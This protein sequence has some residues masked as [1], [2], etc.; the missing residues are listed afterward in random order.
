[1]RV[2]VS[3]TDHTEPPKRSALQN[4]TAV[5][6]ASRCL[7]AP[8][9]SAC[10]I[11]IS[12]GWVSSSRTAAGYNSGVGM[13]ELSRAVESPFPPPPGAPLLQPTSTHSDA[14]MMPACML[15]SRPQIDWI[16][17]LIGEEV[18]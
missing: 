2:I 7:Y 10:S 3:S 1:M 11:C 4:N 6:C 17:S 5:D 9:P 16:H 12:G 18:E 15:N 14:V 8:H 13:L